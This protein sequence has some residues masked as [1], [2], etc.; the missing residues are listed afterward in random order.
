MHRKSGIGC[1]RSTHWCATAGRL[2]FFI[3]YST[4]GGVSSSPWEAAI[5]EQSQAVNIQEEEA[6]VNTFCTLCQHSHMEQRKALPIA[7]AW[8]GED[9]ASSHA[10][11]T[12]GSLSIIRI[13]SGLPLLSTAYVWMCVSVWCVYLCLSRWLVCFWSDCGVCQ[14]CICGDC[15]ACLHIY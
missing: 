15:V 7:W 8:P 9:F 11:K 3:K 4:G 14:M 13:H 1:S 12:I 5:G 6:S 10:P 2:S